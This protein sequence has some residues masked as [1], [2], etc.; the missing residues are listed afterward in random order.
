MGF[1]RRLLGSSDDRAASDDDAPAVAAPRTDAAGSPEADER[2]YELDLLRAEHERL[3]ELR[4]R[5]LRYADYAWQPPAEGGTRRADDGDGDGD[6]VTIRLRHVATDELLAHEVARLH[7]I[8][9]DAFG[10]DPEE[11]FTDEDWAHALGGRHV[12][13]EDDEAI[14]GHAAVVTRELHVGGRPL[15]TGYVEAVAIEPARHGQ[16]LGSRLMGD[17]DAYVEAHFELGALGTERHAFYGRLGWRTWLGP[18]SVRLPGGEEQ[19]T[20][21]ED[22][23]ILV[24]ATPTTPAWALDL[25]QP[26]SC[27]WRPGDAW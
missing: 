21:D 23:Y 3:D 25:G 13:V 9:R 2:A 24:L 8:M 5:Q 19:P 4:Q 26:I 12:L 17:I 6:K 14:V 15:H 1:L 7:E 27:E 11:R 20:P 10:D 18:S 16:G 22:G